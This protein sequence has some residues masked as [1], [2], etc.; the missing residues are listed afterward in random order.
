MIR[1]QDFFPLA[2]DTQPPSRDPAQQLAG[3]QLF[4]PLPRNLSLNEP[5]LTKGFCMESLGGG[6]GSSNPLCVPFLVGSTK[7]TIQTVG[8]GQVL[9]DGPLVPYLGGWTY[10]CW[11]V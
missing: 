11:R 7:A 1:V 2:E 5:Y 4:S 9:S 3:R 10:T 6:R 8:V